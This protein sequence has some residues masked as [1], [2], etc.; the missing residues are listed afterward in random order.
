M[1]VVTRLAKSYK[2]SAVIILPCVSA[3][4]GLLLEGMDVCCGDVAVVRLSWSF[5]CL[6][7]F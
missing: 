5:Q 7:E 1:F 3:M 4:V 6:R 2:A